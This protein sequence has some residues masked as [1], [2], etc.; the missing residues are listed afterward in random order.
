MKAAIHYIPCSAPDHAVYAIISNSYRWPDIFEPCRNVEFIEKRNGTEVIR[1]I[2]EVNGVEM[3]W[4]S[5]RLLLDQIHGIDFE[6]TPPTAAAKI[7]AR[8]LARGATIRER[9]PAFYRTQFRG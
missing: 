1:I 4:V 6:T 5:H 2:A 8:S 3:Q 9:K 7:H